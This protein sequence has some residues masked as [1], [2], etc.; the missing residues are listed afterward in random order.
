M[1]I[2][3]MKKMQF[4]SSVLHLDLAIFYQIIPETLRVF[5]ISRGQAIIQAFY[6]D[7]FAGLSVGPSPCHTIAFLIVL[8]LLTIRA[9]GYCVYSHVFTVEHR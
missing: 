7:R 2:A 6:F 9:Q 1:D 5:I 4:S 3:V 8:S